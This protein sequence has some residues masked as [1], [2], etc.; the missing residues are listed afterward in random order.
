[1]YGAFSIL[2]SYADGERFPMGNAKEELEST[3]VCLS[4]LQ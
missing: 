2:L 3:G 4:P 1:M